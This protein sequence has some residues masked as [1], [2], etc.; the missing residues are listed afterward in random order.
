MSDLVELTRR[1]IAARLKELRPVV[2]EYERLEAAESALA[3]VRG[4]SLAAALG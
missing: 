2:E 3:G 4:P 1:E